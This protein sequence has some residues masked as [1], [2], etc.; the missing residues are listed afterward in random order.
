MSRTVRLLLLLLLATAPFTVTACSADPGTTSNE[1]AAQVQQVDAAEAR[2]LIDDGA[3]VIDVRTPEEF[4]TGHLRG[5][6]NIDVQAADFHEQV[7]DLDKDANYVLYCRSGSRAGAA[8]DMMTDM[9]FTGVVNA[10][11]YDTLAA[12]GLPS[13]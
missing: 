5:A 13:E 11:G 10:G 6:T 4:A 12:A 7:G 1:T 8:A 9:G 2:A 3:A